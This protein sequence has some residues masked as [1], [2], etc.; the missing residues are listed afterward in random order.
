MIDQG[1]E[2]DAI[3]KTF[4]ELWLDE[5]CDDPEIWNATFS[6][7]SAAVVAVGVASLADAGI[8]SQ[9]VLCDL[10]IGNEIASSHIRASESPEDWDQQAWTIGMSHGVDGPKG[11]LSG[12]M[13]IDVF[14]GLLDL[15]V[16]QYSRAEEG[17]EIEVPI[18][19]P[20]R[21]RHPDGGVLVFGPGGEF[22]LLDNV[23]DKLSPTATDLYQEGITNGL[24]AYRRLG[25]T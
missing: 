15:S 19:V 21:L 10:V 4:I 6:G 11:S 8:E 3:I 18:W 2:T 23:T 9:P 7:R 17:I 5:G 1:T 22:Y 13:V 20:A 25:T 12:H 14:G 24:E 16:V